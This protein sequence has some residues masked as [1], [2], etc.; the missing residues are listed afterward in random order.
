MVSNFE[1]EKG[2]KE[3]KLIS[4]SHLVIF[5]M[6][7]LLGTWMYIF[8]GG[9]ETNKPIQDEEKRVIDDSQLII[10]SFGNLNVK[11]SQPQY[12]GLSGDASY[13]GLT[14]RFYGNENESNYLLQLIAVPP[15]R[16]M[17]YQFK[18]VVKYVESEDGTI[19]KYLGI[20]NITTH[21]SR[22]TAVYTQQNLSEAL[23]YSIIFEAREANE[24]PNEETREEIIRGASIYELY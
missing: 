10:L 6:L 15:T 11:I 1:Q 3:C 17:Y 13:P 23:E 8:L 9:N 14:A 5:I 16:G 21:V 22:F 12:V 4:S 19:W 18:D 7:V 2:G 20:N 24:I